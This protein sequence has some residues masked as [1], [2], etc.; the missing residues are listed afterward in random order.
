MT[1]YHL[2][3]FQQ[4]LMFKCSL[5]YL[6]ISFY[7]EMKM[8]ILFNLIW[9]AIIPKLSINQPLLILLQKKVNYILYRSAEN[10]VRSMSPIMS[11]LTPS[12]CNRI[13]LPI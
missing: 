5:N 1:K 2:F 3:S 8:L 13:A 10:A 9:K 4:I 6:L 12:F 11:L 7:V